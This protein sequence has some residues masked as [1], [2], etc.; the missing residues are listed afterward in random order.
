MTLSTARHR[1]RDAVLLILSFYLNV[2]DYL[3]VL[4]NYLAAIPNSQRRFI[5]GIAAGLYLTARQ[6]YIYYRKSQRR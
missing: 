5:V 2:M 3:L 4:R 6:A 1:R